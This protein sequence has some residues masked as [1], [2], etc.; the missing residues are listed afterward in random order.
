MT[1]DDSPPISFLG[2]PLPFP[3]STA[4]LV[5][6]NWSSHKSKRKNA[7][8]KQWVPTKR[9]LKR[10]DVQELTSVL[11]QLC[12]KKRCLKGLS[13]AELVTD[14]KRYQQLSEADKSMWIKN[15]L[16]TMMGG[17]GTM[18]YKVQRKVTYSH[19]LI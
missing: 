18:K 19:S 15:Y 5:P 8:V 17:S 3:G 9:F 1:E 10:L 11:H 13:M 4:P 2:Q 7:K 14:R 16:F 6:K 12:C